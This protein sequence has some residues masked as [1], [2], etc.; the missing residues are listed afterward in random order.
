MAGTP[1]DALGPEACEGIEHALSIARSRVSPGLH[2]ADQHTLGA[3]SDHAQVES[4]END[5]IDIDIPG[6]LNS[7][8][9]DF[10]FGPY[11]VEQ[12]ACPIVEYND[13]RATNQNT[14]TAGDQTDGLVSGEGFKRSNTPDSLTHRVVERRGKAKRRR[15]QSDLPVII[16]SSS[17][18]G[19]SESDVESVFENSGS[20][21]SK[22][23]PL[24]GSPG[25]SLCYSDDNDVVA[26]PTTRLRVR[27]PLPVVDLA[28][29]QNDCSMAELH[30]S[31][32][33]DHDIDTEIDAKDP[34]SDDDDELSHSP[35]WYRFRPSTTTIEGN[36]TELEA[37]RRYVALVEDVFRDREFHEVLGKEYI[38]GEVH[39]LVDWV[40][41]LV[42]GRVL[43]KAKA[44]PLISQFEA[45]CQ[46]QRETRKRP[47]TH[48]SN[49]SKATDGIQRK[50][51]G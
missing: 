6:D 7:L 51:R 21:R 20:K 26:K 3:E 44:Q 41:T 31:S 5:A 18:C 25:S 4:V 38:D 10:D 8:F 1:S 36:G 29:R 12:E 43:H 47:G 16:D 15:S 49:G 11:L 50:R 14:D 28:E 45:S 24:G 33:S 23:G 37:R 19:A 13:S 27:P 42:R 46:A 34:D 17:D 2:T 30:D 22:S 48:R 35:S 40:P 9:G 32:K 39:Y